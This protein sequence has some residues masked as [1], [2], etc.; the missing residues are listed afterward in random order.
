MPERSQRAYI[1]HPSDI[2]IEIARATRDRKDRQRLHNISYGGLCCGC[3]V[4]VKPG[5]LIWLSIALVEPPFEAKARV[6]WCHSCASGYDLGVEFMEAEDA[7]RA[8]MVEQICHI[9]RYKRWAFDNQGRELSA[10]Q[11]AKEWIGKYA[12]DFPNPAHEDVPDGNA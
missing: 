3:S 1:R 11:A 6:V 9:E 5:A 12:A 10:E 8:R 4:Y 2:P 7:F